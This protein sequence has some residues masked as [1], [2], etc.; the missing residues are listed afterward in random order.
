MAYKHSKG[1]QVIGDLK[2]A[3][4]AQRDTQIDF[5]EDYIGFVTSGSTSLVLSGS[6]VGIGT[7]TPEYRLQVAGNIGINQYIYHNGDNNTL[8]NF[9]DDRIRLNAGGINFIDLE[10]DSSTP[11]PLTINNGGNRINFRVVDRNSDLLLKT[12][13]EDYW[14]GLY[15]AGDQKLVTSNT[16]IEVSGAILIS[17]ESAT[18]SQP[19]SGKG[20]LYSKSDGKLYWR[21]NLIGETELTATGDDGGGGG[22]SSTPE[23][24]KVGISSDFNVTGGASDPYQTLLLDNVEFDTFTGGAGWNTGSYNFV[25]K[26]AGYYEFQASF[27]FDAIQS[28]ITQYQIYL[29][30]SGSSSTNSSAGVPFIALNQYNNN[31][32]QID[33]RTFHLSTIANFSVNQSASIQVRQIDGTANTTKI[34]GGINQTFLTIRKL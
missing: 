11:Y 21:S 9:T 16:G 25:A 33:M 2:A 7:T 15:Y 13:S 19:A 34:K 31:P 6:K 29:V 26:E 30:S 4:D 32:A 5:E 10:K 22:E 1:S 18:P 20:Y 17:S 28:D 3:D 27:V 24:L 12:N 8:I 23:V 14:A